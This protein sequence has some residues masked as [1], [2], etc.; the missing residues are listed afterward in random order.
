MRLQFDDILSCAMDVRWRSVQPTACPIVN[1]RKRAT[2]QQLLVGPYGII[3]LPQK[4]NKNP[5]STNRPTRARRALIKAAIYGF[6]HF[7]NPEST[8]ASLGT[9]TGSISVISFKMQ[10]T[11]PNSG[12][13]SGFEIES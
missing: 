10:T 6:I 1:P 3:L 13:Q 7:L 9:V 5:I 8:L 11:E 2:L 4:L 12:C